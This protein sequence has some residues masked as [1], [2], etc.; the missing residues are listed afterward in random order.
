MF[1]LHSWV[2]LFCFVFRQR[3]CVA[4]SQIFIQKIPLNHKW[5]RYGGGHLRCGRD[6]SVMV[7]TLT[8]ILDIKLNITVTWKTK[9]PAVNIVNLVPND[10]HYGFTVNSWFCTPL[11]TF[12]AMNC[13]C[14]VSRISNNSSS[15]YNRLHK[16]W[17]EFKDT[18]KT[19]LQNIRE[20]TALSWLKH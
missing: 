5:L 19:K 2:V 6:I 13:P 10:N 3:V 8:V 17:L 9:V 15:D 7:E 11:S 12:L 4:E 18:T 16:T 14:T 20:L 1:N